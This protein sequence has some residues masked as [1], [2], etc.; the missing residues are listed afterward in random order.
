MGRHE[1]L[2]VA[3]RLERADAQHDA[4][5]SA[6]GGL[7]QPVQLVWLEAARRAFDAAPVGAQANQLERVREQGV[8][9]CA[10]VEAQG[11]DLRRAKIDAEEGRAARLDGFVLPPRGERLHRTHDADLGGDRQG[12][13]SGGE[14]GS[15][16]PAPHR[17]TRRRS[18]AKGVSSQVTAMAGTFGTP[19]SD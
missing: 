5:A 6:L 1:E 15:G 18:Q 10:R 2:G 14:G 4:F 12:G 19:T 16:A 9:R 7:D 17:A 13:Q 8:Q 11:V 3:E